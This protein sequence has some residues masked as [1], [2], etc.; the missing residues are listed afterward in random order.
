MFFDG[1]QAPSSYFRTPE[2]IAWFY[3]DA[4]KKEKDVVVNSYFG[5]D[6]RE[7]KYGDVIH[8]EGSTMS[9]VSPKTWMMWDM[10]R[11]EWNC[12][13]NEFGI[14]VRDGG[15]WEWVYREPEDLI[16]VFVDVV[17]KGGF[18]CVQMFNT[19]QAENMWEI[20]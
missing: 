7:G 20:G 17:S 1:C 3:N 11:N 15:K 14:H 16:H 4:D 18:W 9:S 2:L 10:I 6:Q 5:N 8:I 13:V 19:K 12:W